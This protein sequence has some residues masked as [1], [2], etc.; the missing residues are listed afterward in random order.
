MSI[1]SIS[2]AMA[3]F[4][5]VNAFVCFFFKFEQIKKLCIDTFDAFCR[6]VAKLLTVLTI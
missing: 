4:V 3:R 1:L 5:T 2:Y 6:S